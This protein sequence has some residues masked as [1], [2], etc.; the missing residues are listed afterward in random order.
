MSP[1][2]M[3]M[4]LL[5]P[6]QNSV[7]LRYVGTWALRAALAISFLAW[8]GVLGVVLRAVWHRLKL[9]SGVSL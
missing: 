6:G 1:N 2:N 9:Q 3:A 5:P 7:E 4:V 8:F